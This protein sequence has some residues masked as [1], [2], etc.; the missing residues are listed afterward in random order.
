M[1][2]MKPIENIV[3]KGE[4]GINQHFHLLPQYFLPFLKQV[5]IFSITFILLSA[6]ASDLDQCKNLS[7]GEFFIHFYFVV[8]KCFQLGAV[9]KFVISERVDPI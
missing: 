9:G 1:W 2:E 4:N 3:R 6:N 7:F 5:S 8:C